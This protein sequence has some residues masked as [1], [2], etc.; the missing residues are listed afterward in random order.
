MTNPSASGRSLA[1][2]LLSPIAEVRRCEVRKTVLL[3]LN[4]FMVLA[5]YY[6][7]K[8]I[9]ESLIL[10]QGGAAIKAYSSA[11]QALLLLAL[12]P[13]FGALASRVNRIRLVRGVTLFF[14][15]NIAVFFVLGRL[16]VLI[17]VPF[18][19]WVGIFN[20][21]VI[22]QFWGFANDLNT[23]EQGK[24]LFPV[25]GL[26]SSLGAWVGS[27]YAGDVIRAT[28]PFPL[29]LIAAVV[30]TLSTVVASAIERSHN[31]AGSHEQAEADG[32]LE[33]VGGFEI[34]RH[35][36]YLKLIALMVVVLNLVNTSG[37][38]LFGKFVVDASVHMYG[39]GPGSLAARQQF[40]GGVYGH[41]FSYV[42]LVGVLLQLFAVS[43]I[44]KRV[45]VGGALFIHPLLVLSGYVMMLK[46]PSVS[47]MQW[48]KVFDNGVDYSLGNTARQ[49]L[50][51]PTSRGAKYKA[52]QAVD[53]FAM[54]A[55]DVVEAGVVFVGE[56]LAFTVSMFAGLN[57]ALA[58]GWLAIVAVLN[59]A[60]QKQAGTTGI[61]D[62]APDANRPIAD[63]LPLLPRERPF[64]GPEGGGVAGELGS[65]L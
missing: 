57:V 48:L 22:A 60:Y 11:G 32:P 62:A 51:L 9:R 5:A 4:L 36:R 3:A 10:T 63:P 59:A 23:L 56:R 35:D 46:A 7:L 33:R 39:A 29:M 64:E 21:M 14:V 13:A 61:G 58:L 50:W 15:S 8:T 52:K 54:R 53:S 34:I 31:R 43:R 45:G 40:V 41:L 2:R 38:Y 37:E 27:M 17:A 19:L 24:R 18:F 42:N 20:V 47:T 30:L 6:M 25:I 44:L 1:A 26:G 65:V 28:G 16:G 12:I 55:G 49:A